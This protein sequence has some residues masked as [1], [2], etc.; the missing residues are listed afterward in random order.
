MGIK[1]DFDKNGFV[2]IKHPLIAEFKQEL[3]DEI[4]SFLDTLLARF[5][6]RKVSKSDATLTERISE[7]FHVE[8]KEEITSKLYEL[9]PTLPKFFGQVSNSLILDTIS[10]LKVLSPSVGTI[11]LLRIDRPNDSFRITPMH[12]DYWYSFLSKNSIVVW[13]TLEKIDKSSGFLKVVPGSH[14]NGIANFNVTEKNRDSYQ[15]TRAIN[16]D[17]IVEVDLEDDEILIFSQLLLHQS[18]V[19]NS[20]KVRISTQLRFND[21]VSAEALTKT[22]SVTHSDYVKTKQEEFLE[23]ST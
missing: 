7:V 15:A 22:F 2:V 3:I 23:S 19:N 6:F 21:L 12:Q 4:H 20:S 1:S 14:K 13:F 10:K 17:D 16:S 8:E 5:E 18:G 11:P 9:V